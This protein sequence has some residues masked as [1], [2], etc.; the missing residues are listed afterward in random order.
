VVELVLE[1]PLKVNHASNMPLSV[2]GTGITFQPASA[3]AHSSNEPVLALGTGIT[4]DSPLSGDHPIDA[5]VR[6]AVV[7]EAG[8]QGPVTPNQWFGG[9]ALSPAAGAMILRDAAGMVV[10]S[11]NYG[12]MV[13]PWAAEGYQA[14]SGAGQGGCRVAS[15]SAGGRRGGAPAVAANRSAGRFPDGADSDSNCTDFVLQAAAA[16]PPSDASAGGGPTPGKAN[17]YTR[18]Q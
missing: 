1:A 16:T 13:D 4:L 17:Q 12:L 7:K 10:D 15:P 3:F 2:R 14:A 6:D 5:V 9:P 11:L 8:Y 18:P